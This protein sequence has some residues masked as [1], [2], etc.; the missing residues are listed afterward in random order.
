MV[1]SK[2]DLNNKLLQLSQ[3]EMIRLVSKL[4]FSVP[5][6]Q[7]PINQAVLTENA[8]VDIL[9]HME[10]YSPGECKTAL[11]ERV[12]TIKDKKG[13]VLLYFAFV[14]GIL[15][16]KDDIDFRFIAVASAA[17]GKAM[18]ILEKNRNLWDELLDQSFEIATK[19]YQMD[20]TAAGKAVDY[21]VK[22]KRG[23][24]KADQ[25]L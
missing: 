1:Y 22:V 9:A 13:K 21:Y 16:R 23:F 7:G 3:E 10:A 12:K 5:N 4:Y 19:F 6:T 14:E 25:S 18:E 17:F 8:A 24:D 20:G 15:D 2:E 11:A